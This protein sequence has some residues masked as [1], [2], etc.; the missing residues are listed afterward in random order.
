VAHGGISTK[1]ANVAAGKRAM[2]RRKCSGLSR[3]D[4]RLWDSVSEA[5]HSPVRQAATRAGRLPRCW[6]GGFSHAAVV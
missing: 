5:D 3:R 1:A 4:V 6:A 2:L